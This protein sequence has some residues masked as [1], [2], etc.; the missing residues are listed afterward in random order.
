[1]LSASIPLMFVLGVLSSLSPCFFPLFPSFLAYVAN[2]EKDGRKGAVV[3]FTCTL[4]IILSFAIYGMFASILALPL[5]R[6]GGLLRSVFGV[7]I[8]FLGVIMFT[9]M[10]GI[11]TKIRPPQRLSRVKG[12]LGTFVLGLL[13]T[14]IAAPCTMPI[15]LSAILLAVIPGNFLLTVV[16]LITFG[17]GTGTPFILSSL[18]IATTRDFVSRRYQSLAP[19]WEYGSALVLMLIGLV[20][21]LSGLGVIPYFME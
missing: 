1:V 2:V 17:F 10:R 20:L 3:G 19:F 4:G 6:H 9:P 5:L 16:N 11:F 7:F 13:Y 15:F 8:I 18:L 12:L 14:L 21:L